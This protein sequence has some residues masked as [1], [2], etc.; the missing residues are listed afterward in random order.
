M[1]GDFGILI[2]AGIPGGRGVTTG[3]TGTGGIGTGG[4]ILLCQGS[5]NAIGG[6]TL[7]G[8][9]TTGGADFGSPGDTVTM[10]D[11]KEGSGSKGRRRSRLQRHL[12]TA[13]VLSG[14]ARCYATVL[15]YYLLNQIDIV[16]RVAVRRRDIC[17]PAILCYRNI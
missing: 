8:G 15:L 1:L 3:G 4:C 17:M 6:G 5:I 14:T 7:G 9:P 10:Q 13:L 16:F 2:H 11:V 12:N